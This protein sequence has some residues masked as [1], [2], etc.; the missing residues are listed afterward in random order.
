MEP[1]YHLCMIEGCTR[2]AQQ[3]HEPLRAQLSK[4]DYDDPRFLRWL[5]VIHHTAGQECRHKLGYMM[6]K[7]HFPEYDGIS[8]EEYRRMKRGDS[9]VE[10]FLGKEG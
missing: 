7:K 4:D 9:M 6:F 2:E 5:C 1:P 3:H 8:V 10:G